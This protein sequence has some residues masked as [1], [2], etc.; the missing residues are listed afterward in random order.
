MIFEGDDN[1]L[2]I[3]KMNVSNIVI[4]MIIVTVSQPSSSPIL[5]KVFEGDG[6]IKWLNEESFSAAAL[7]CIYLRMLHHLPY[8]QMHSVELQKV[9]TFPGEIKDVSVKTNAIILMRKMRDM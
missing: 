7:K 1:I 6:P 8:Y 3:C 4:V 9:I 2:K 5:E